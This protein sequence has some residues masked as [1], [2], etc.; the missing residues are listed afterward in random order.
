[1][2]I[3]LRAKNSILWAFSEAIFLFLFSMPSFNIHPALLWPRHM[4]HKDDWGM[5]GILQQLL[6]QVQEK[7]RI[8]K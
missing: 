2:I 4:E 5:L 6:Y 8:F 3:I 1:M 7:R